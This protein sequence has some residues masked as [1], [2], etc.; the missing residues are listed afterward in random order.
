MVLAG[1]QL[2]GLAGLC[3]RFE[4]K[5]WVKTQHGMR[6]DGDRALLNTHGPDVGAI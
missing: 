2:T 3:T 6:L 1:R 4:V 5:G